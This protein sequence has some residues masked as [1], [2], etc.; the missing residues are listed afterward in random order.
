MMLD[1]LYRKKA[2]VQH[3]TTIALEVFTLETYEQKISN[4]NV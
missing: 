3:I 1:T 4:F 2:S